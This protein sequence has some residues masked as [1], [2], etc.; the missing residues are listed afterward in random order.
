[1]PYTRVL[2]TD[3]I[4]F[5]HVSCRTAEVQLAWSQK[6]RLEVS[7]DCSLPAPRVLIPQSI[8]TL[9]MCN[10][11]VVDLG[12]LRFQSQKSNEDKECRG[13]KKI[14]VYRSWSDDRLEKLLLELVS[15]MHSAFFRKPYSW[16]S[17]PLC[18][19]LHVFTVNYDS[20]VWRLFGVFATHFRAGSFEYRLYTLNECS[21]LKHG[22]SAL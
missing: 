22:D 13:L 9:E 4:N 18:S 3:Y 12:Q 7:V 16:Y 15:G 5:V 20:D 21:T 6:S 11:L 10:T 17:A 19:T 1:M 2:S 8:E 14:R